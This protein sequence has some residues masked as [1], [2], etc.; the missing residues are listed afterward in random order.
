M[1]IKH[2]DVS[3]GGAVL[4]VSCPFCDAPIQ[5]RGYNLPTHLREDCEVLR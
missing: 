1:A 2:T 3:G 4:T 5:G